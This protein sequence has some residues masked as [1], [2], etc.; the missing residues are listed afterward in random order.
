[1]VVITLTSCPAKLRGD[2]TR[3]L[4]EIDTGVYVGNLSARV[5]DGI[6]QRICDN[7]GSGRAVMTY[8]AANE[9]KLDFRI[10][11]SEWIPTDHDGIKL[12]K[13]MFPS[14]S[15]SKYKAGSKNVIRHKTHLEQR[16]RKGDDTP[17]YTVIDIE[18]TGIK[19]DERIIELGALRI[20]S[21]KETGSFSALVK[22]GKPVPKEIM[23]LT[24]IT[25]ELLESEGIEPD[26]A[27]QLFTEFCGNDTLV[28]HNI[29]FD[30]GFLQRLCNETGRTFL[31]NRT[32]DTI[33]IA[34]RK[35]DIADGYSLASICGHFGIEIKTQHRA[36]EDCKLTY[37]IFE[38]LKEIEGE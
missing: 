1:M 35:T 8:A 2:L 19:T 12:V 9:Q 18:T 27:I 33:R 31:R 7:I 38:K 26:R 25:D 32:I 24:G 3:W 28:G 20:R 37:R 4:F 6:W 10:C 5:R 23:K 30:I 16:K 36:I 34:K 17:D 21:G 22:C 14:E 11:G 29:S 13:R 15:D